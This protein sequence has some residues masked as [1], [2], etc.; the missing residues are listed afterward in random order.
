VGSVVVPLREDLLGD[1]LIELMV[2][3]AAAGAVLL[4]AAAN[5][6]SLLLSRAVSRRAELAVRVSLGASRGQLLRQML[7]EGLV[8]S[9]AGGVAGLAL[10]P[11]A[12]RAIVDLVPT[13]LPGQ[14]AVLSA[15]LLIFTTILSVATGLG[16]SLVPA[17][18]ASSVS[19]AG[20]L[21]QG[22]RSVVSRHRLGQLMVV[23]QVAAALALMICTGLLLKTLGNLRNIDLGF[24]R[25]QVL[26]LRT[27]LPRDKYADGAQRR[28]FYDRVLEGTR[29][30]PGVEAAAYASTLPFQSIGNTNS[31][32]ID[33]G[34]MV[35]NDERDALFRVGTTDYLRTLDAHVVAGRLIDERD[36]PD[37]PKVVVVNETLARKHW[38]AGDALGHKISFGGPHAVDAPWFT[39]VGVVRDVR[40][41]GYE[42]EMKPG[43]YL[44]QAQVP[45]TWA[46]PETLVV[47][48]TG[49]PERITPDIR[50]IV[51]SVDPQ[52]PIAAVR[53]L[54]EIV[55]LDVADRS[56]QLMLLSGFAALAIL[57]ASLGLYG[58]LAYTVAERRHEIGLR[59]ALGASIGLVI[60]DVVGA[61][62]KVT[63][64]GVGIGL[65]AAYLAARAF[66]SMLYG[67]ATTDP[68]TIAR[69]V[70]LFV[71]VALVAATIPAL[72]AARVDPMKALREE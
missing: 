63:T 21:K 67:V 26:T 29:A 13:S 3:M 10:A 31:Y 8:L 53:T 2:L 65:A 60:R 1:T 40:E 36:G 37:A 6:A 35:A 50:R 46:Q 12:M 32:Q 34:A 54:D 15:P 43:V 28:G 41:R 4:I 48:T 7:G 16:L 23:G 64:L 49:A 70:A 62:L 68:A 30:V 22:S 72:R 51:A 69:S 57:L 38:P 27:T 9:L 56:Q 55:D 59:M 44:P 39:I 52:Q 14:G 66:Q 45:D 47:R 42:R 24:R 18:Q 11:L 5:V 33:A 19:V 58:V 71:A 20:D 17:L 25:E 61:G